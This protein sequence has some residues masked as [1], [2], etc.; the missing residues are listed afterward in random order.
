[1]NSVIADTR[2]SCRGRAETSHVELS[3]FVALELRRIFSSS[4]IYRRGTVLCT[5]ARCVYTQRTEFLILAAP[6]SVISCTR[7]NMRDTVVRAEV[8]SRRG[9]ISK[10]RGKICSVYSASR[11]GCSPMVL[12]GRLRAAVYFLRPRKSTSVT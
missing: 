5:R 11:R 12:R 3:Y 1:M 8:T 9:G 7:Y 2:V 10:L 6:V 4:I